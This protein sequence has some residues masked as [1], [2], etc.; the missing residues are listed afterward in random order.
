MAPAAAPRHHR[1]C[2]PRRRPGGRPALRPGSGPGRRQDR[3]CCDD[4]RRR[5]VAAGHHGPRRGGR[6]SPAETVSW[7]AGCGGADRHHRRRRRRRRDLRPAGSRSTASP[8]SCSDPTSTSSAPRP[9]PPEPVRCSRRSAPRSN[10]RSI[11]ARTTNGRRSTMKIANLDGRL[12]LVVDGGVIDVHDASEGRFGPDPSSGYDQWDDL[13]SWADSATGEVQPL[14]E[15]ALR[16]S[17]ARSPPGLRHRPELRQPRRR[18]RHGAAGHARRVHQV[19]GLHRRPVR[20]RR[21][22]GRDGRLGGGA[23]GGRWGAG[24]TGCPRPRPGTTSP[25]SASARTSRT[26]WCSSPPAPSSRWAS[27]TG[28]S[29]PPVRGWSRPTSSTTPTTW[30]SAARS[31]A[32]R[33]RTT[34][35]A[36]WCSASAG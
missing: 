8:P 12:A 28:P 23:G 27:P 18:V 4:R 33:C 30:P 34:G 9:I 29:A 14:D 15:Q 17:L 25:G 2:H 13:R 26:G 19:P 3:P 22:V 35:P 21:A 36:A 1:R 16:R 7:F 32:R 24:P 11:P 6:R 31:T 5:R 20:R 10:D